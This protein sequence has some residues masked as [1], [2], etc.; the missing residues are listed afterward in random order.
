MKKNNLLT[1]GQ[2]SKLSD[3]HI[4]AIR[5]YEKIGIFPPSYI[6]SSNAYRY[7]SN[8]HIIYLQLIKLCVTYG[9]SLKSFN[10][11]WADTDKIDLDAIIKQA[12][13]HISEKKKQLLSDENFLEALTSELE[14]SQNLHRKPK[15]ETII[16]PKHEDFLLIPFEGDIFSYHYYESFYKALDI[17]DKHQTT[18][19]N[20]VGCY[21]MMKAQKLKQFLALKIQAH[22]PNTGSLEVLH[23]IDKPELI[24]HIGP[25]AVAD[26]LSELAN[27]DYQCLILETYE[28]PYNIIKPHLELR[29]F[30]TPTDDNPTPQQA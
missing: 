29:L 15:T 28:S 18:Y 5:Y 22:T 13:L 1:I 14:F 2:L 6:D 12:K 27:D 25:E 11:Y 26:E 30:L 17:I 20:K 21:Y 3:T 16:K 9:I 23:L 24:K 19:F 10:Q 7:Y 4:K 8:S